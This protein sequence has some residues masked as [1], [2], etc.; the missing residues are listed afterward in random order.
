MY[1]VDA[2]SSFGAIDVNMRAN[3]IDFVVSSANKC[4][5]VHLTTYSWLSVLN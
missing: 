4:I 3:A 1:F 2:M 5:Q